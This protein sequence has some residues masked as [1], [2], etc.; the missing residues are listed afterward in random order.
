M[1]KDVYVITGATSGIGLQTAL[2]FDKE[3][4]LVLFDLGEEKLIRLQRKLHEKNIES[5]VVA[6]DVTSNKDIKKLVNSVKQLGNFKSMVHCAGISDEM[7][8]VE[9]IFNVN[10]IG[11]KKLMDAFYPLANKSVF[12]NISSVAG[13]LAPDRFITN[14][15]LLNPQKKGFIKK[16]KLFANN[17]SK[18]YNYSKKGVC[19]ISKKEV[20]R[21]RDKK[22]RVMV[23]SPG[24]INTPMLKESINTNPGVKLMINAVPQKRAG[25]A[26]EVSD[27]IYEVINNEYINGTDI[28][29]DGGFLSINKQTDVFGVD[30]NK[31]RYLFVINWYLIL[32]FLLPNVYRLLNPQSFV[33][34]LNELHYLYLPLITAIITIIFNKD[35][36]SW[37]LTLIPFVMFYFLREIFHF[38]NIYIGL[39]YPLIAFVIS[40]IVKRLNKTK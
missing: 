39:I 8:T 4:A 20:V 36:F 21:W 15:L 27:L 28:I 38:E 10:L 40:I 12:I 26:K 6:G 33:L 32:F 23:I 11:T 22:S 37:F 19:L 16:I 30:K 35:K 18:A 31:M 24:T 14:N 2:D 17:P 13:H 5:A 9:Q 34:N 7:G 3:A 29:I 25:N 1:K